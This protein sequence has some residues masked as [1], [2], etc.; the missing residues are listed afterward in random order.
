MHSEVRA[1]WN[2]R[3]IMWYKRAAEHCSF[4]SELASILSKSIEKNLSIAEL[5]CGLGYFSNEMAKLG[6]DIK[7]FDIDPEAIDFAKDSFG[8]SLFEKRDCLT[9]SIKR[10]VAICIFFGKITRDDNFEKLS[11]VARDKLIYVT[12]G[13]SERHISTSEIDSFLESKGITPNKTEVTIPFP[14]PLLDEKECEE[15][16]STYYS[17]E[18]RDLKRKSIRK[19][20]DERYKYILENNKKLTIYSIQTGGN[21]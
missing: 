20:D 5:G 13:G 14:Q 18:I 9:S 4:H 17:G 19:T 11:S 8:S 21:R 1:W 3:R 15:F 6:Y 2:E 7:G 12:G 16:L 10:D